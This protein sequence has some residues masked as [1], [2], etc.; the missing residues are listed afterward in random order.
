MKTTLIFLFIF[1]TILSST[2]YAQTQQTKTW[3]HK[4]VESSKEYSKIQQAEELL[5]KGEAQN[6][7]KI[8]ENVVT[9]DPE[10]PPDQFLFAILYLWN[11]NLEGARQILQGTGVKYPDYPGVYVLLGNLSVQE[12]RNLE[13]SLLYQKA[14]Q[15][16]EG[17]TWKPY[18]SQAFLD[19]IYT[20]LAAIAERR[21]NWNETASYL[22]KLLK[23]REKDGLLRQRIAICYFRAGKREN[24]EKELY[25]AKKES[26][27]VEAPELSLGKLYTEQK[28]MDQAKKWIELATQKNP[29]DNYVFF[30]VAQWYWNQ[31]DIEKAQAHALQSIQLGNNTVDVKMLLGLIAREQKKFD[32]AEKIFTEVYEKNPTYFSASNQL[33]LVLLEQKEKEK[34][35]KSVQLA[36]INARLH[37]KNVIALSTWAWILFRLNNI[38][39]SEKIFQEIVKSGNVPAETAYYLAHVTFKQNRLQ[40]TKQWLQAAKRTPFRFVYKKEVEE[41]LGRL[42]STPGSTEK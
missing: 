37:S 11:N 10:L 22:E 42:A 39:E 9:Q 20:G 3:V 12:G 33:A 21:E 18:Q 14:L 30:Q 36:S 19:Q 40:D 25:A 41:W 4:L 6:S 26:D 24:T 34:K 13:A 2:V 7:F 32:E 31:D 1:V 5:R 38:N 16:V 8:L 35:E 27:S 23:L 29:K 17:K 28:M 15:W